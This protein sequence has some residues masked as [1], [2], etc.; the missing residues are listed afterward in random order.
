[1]L[2]VKQ[3]SALRTRI[4][5]GVLA[6]VFVA[7]IIAVFWSNIIGIFVQTNAPLGQAVSRP[8]ARVEAKFFQGSEFSDRI[9]AESDLEV[10]SKGRANPFLNII[11]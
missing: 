5:L 6:V 2:V 10:G 4:L 3:Q 7:T 9:P 11:E 8:A 1:M